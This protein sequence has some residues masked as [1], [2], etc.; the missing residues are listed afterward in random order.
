MGGERWRGGGVPQI[1]CHSHISSGSFQC[2]SSQQYG[3]LSNTSRSMTSVHLPGSVFFSF[4]PPFPP[5]APPLWILEAED[6]QQRKH[7]RSPGSGLNTDTTAAEILP[8]V[9]HSVPSFGCSENCSLSKLY[10]LQ[11]FKAPQQAKIITSVKLSGMAV[12]GWRRH[13]QHEVEIVRSPSAFFFFFAAGLFFIKKN[14]LCNLYSHKT[15]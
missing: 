4:F 8:P 3:L 15:H 5:T 6:S 14:S 2:K 11:F 7:R 1:K 12:E 10:F 9:I 13:V